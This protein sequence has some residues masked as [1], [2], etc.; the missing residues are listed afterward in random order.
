M[1][2]F[3][4]TLRR[5]VRTR[6][7]LQTKAEGRQKNGSRRP[8]NGDRR[9]EFHD[10]DSA[11]MAALYMRETKQKRA[12][13][14]WHT[15]YVESGATVLMVMDDIVL[16]MSKK[17]EAVAGLERLEVVRG[18]N[19][20]KSEFQVFEGTGSVRSGLALNVPKIAHKLVFVAGSSENGH[21]LQFTKNNFVI[22]MKNKVG[23]VSNYA[24]RMYTVD[25]RKVGKQ[26][27]LA[28]SEN[29]VMASNVWHA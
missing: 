8:D 25:S 3:V 21:T 5:T 15:D 16:V 2:L 11:M 24:D 17:N 20:G 27:P 22:K 9:L 4:G 1:K 19:E 10:N 6:G 28:L 26:Q 12:M 29:D 14:A 7:L 23:V 13:Y 18:K